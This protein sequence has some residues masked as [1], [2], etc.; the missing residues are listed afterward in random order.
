MAITQTET[1]AGV[2]HKDTDAGNTPVKDIAHGP[3]TL[4]HFDVGGTVN[5]D[6]LVM[7]YDHANPTVGTTEP[8]ETWLIDASNPVVI[9][10][11]EDG[12]VFDTALSYA[13][14]QASDGTSDPGATVTL[15]LTLVKG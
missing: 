7:L 3:C 5:E 6:D 9:P 2:L 13:I 11:G 14:V 4:Y 12:V 10:L 15:A 1:D 8:I